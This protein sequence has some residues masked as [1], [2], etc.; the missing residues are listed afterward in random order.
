MTDTATPPI[1]QPEAAALAEYLHAQQATLVTADGSYAVSVHGQIIVNKRVVPYHLVPDEGF[2]G[3]T[4]KWRKLN[5]HER[6]ELLHARWNDAARAKLEAQL[7]QCAD[8][9]A[10]IARDYELDPG[11]AYNAFQAKYERA[12]LRCNLAM[13]RIEALQGTRAATRQAEKTRNAVNLS[14]Y[15]ESFTVA[16]GMQRH[17]IAVLGPTNSG[18]THQAMEHL[19]EAKSGVYLAPLRLLALENYHRLQDAEVA[20][21]LVTGEQR[22]V[23]PEATHVAS[24]VEMLNPNRPV[25]VAV[26][27]E[28]QLLDDPDRGAAWTAAVCG[29]PASTVYLLGALEA[30]E[31]IVSLV[32]RVGGTLEIRKLQRKSPLEMEKQ[33]LGSLKNLQPGDVLIAFS[34]REVLNWRDQAIE[35]GFA[36][37]AIYGNLSPEVRQAQAARFVDGETKIIVGTD[38]IGMGLNTPARRVIF[39]TANKW[40]GYAEGTI[41][42]SL[43]K[44]IA[45][46]AGRFGAHEA[47]FVAGLDAGTHKTIAAL[48]REKPEPLPASGFFV[49]PN[50]DYLQQ[51]SAA[52]GQTKLQALLELFAKH[53]NVHDEFFLPA[54]L[55]EQIEKAR[56]LDTLNLSL[57]DR[58]LFSLCPISTKIP[59][60]ERA[61][62][63]WARY[64]ADKRQAPLLRMEGMGGRNELQYLEDTCKLYSAYAWLGYRMPETFPNE[65]MAQ[66][67]MQSTSEKIDNLLQV[68]NTRS[69]HGKR[70]E[71]AKRGGG[72]YGRR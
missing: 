38:A 9:I 47:G 39:T 23:H 29:V 26:I 16:Q 63:D 60:L 31:A 10:A 2:L 61:L 35:Q 27:D 57:A 20:V 25:E 64:R 14:L 54:N 62:Q 45:G 22:K 4:A 53:I 24:T 8:T 6:L 12:S 69:R 56:W 33:P 48:L 36:V 18:K 72:K 58:Y 59:M 28:I 46:R 7:Q 51:I 13:D 15:P 71:Q 52:T 21:S 5:T 1:D 42:A 3:K 30:E 34:R 44:Q 11:S 66:M 68:Q 19:A 70:P 17:F 37:S 67:L 32:K 49:A 41:S 40:D 55:T 50:L 43:A 65:D